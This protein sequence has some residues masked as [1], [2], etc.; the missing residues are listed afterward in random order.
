MARNHL[1]VDGVCCGGS[2]AKHERGA[3][4]ERGEVFL[5]ATLPFLDV[6]TR[7]ARYA[8]RDRHLAEDFV[9]ETYLHAFAAFEPGRIENVKAW[10][11]TICLNIV[12]SDA[13]RRARRVTEVELSP[14]DEPESGNRVPEEAFANVDREAVAGAL[15]QLAD[16]QRLAIVLMDLAGLSA[17]EAGTALGCSRNTVLSRVHRG[18]RRLASLLIEEDVHRDLP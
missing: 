2:P 12:R 15:A 11:V 9:Q 18:R 5:D 6:V 7:V 17:S 4:D 16:E 1:L 13:R 8:S 14:L 3:M 10:L